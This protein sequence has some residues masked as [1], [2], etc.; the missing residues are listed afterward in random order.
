MDRKQ[1]TALVLLDLSKAFDSIDHMSLLKKLRAMGTSKEAIEW[2]RSYLTGRKQSVRIGC[3]TSEPRLISYGVPQGSILGPA[4]FNIY[5]NDLPSVPKVGSLECYVD[6]S[7]LYLSFPVRDTTLA[8]D[9]L[10]EDLRNI[11]AWCCKNSLLINPDKTKLLV[12]GTPQMLMK[13]PDDLSITLL[14]KKIIPSKSAKNLGVTMDCSLTY[15]EHVTQV[16]SKCIG[17]LCQ[18]NRVKYLFD[19]RTLITIIN[20]LVFSKLFYCS[21]VWANT[22]KKNIELL[23]TVQNFA[24]RIVSGTR[25]FDHVTPILKQLQWLPII[26]QLAVRDATM[27]FKCLN[28]LAPPYLCQR[29]KTRSEVHNCNTRNR[30]RLHIPLRRTAAGQRAFTFRGQKL[31][32]SLPDEF[33]SITNLDVFKVKIKQHFLRVF[34]EN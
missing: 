16:T 10:T 28:G 24:A 11:A 6:D 12:L 21:S 17:S 2:F 22:T 27:V 13:I 34:L 32:N 29:F 7:Q 30:D 19:R 26:K 8:A 33:Q 14:S 31:W 4:L 23:Q 3:E 1:V 15:D 20:S 9:Q 25:K 18:I 5:I